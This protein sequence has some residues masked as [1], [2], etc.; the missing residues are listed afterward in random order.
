[1]D[2]LKK[3][4]KNEFQKFM[5]V[6][7]SQVLGA[8]RKRMNDLGVL[9]VAEVVRADCQQQDRQLLTQLSL[10][11]TWVDVENP[12]DKISVPWY[13]QGLDVGEKGPG[14]AYT[15]GEKY[16]LLK[17]FNI[18]TDKDDPDGQNSRVSQPEVKY[19]DGPGE[20]KGL[21]SAEQLEQI[22]TIIRTNKLDPDSVKDY[23]VQNGM[24]Q[25]GKNGP[26]PMTMASSVAEEVLDRKDDFVRAFSRWTTEP[27]TAPIPAS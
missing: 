21:A 24:I 8:L 7:S 19:K 26:D 23:M 12:E 13:A 25:L 11:Y 2:S 18:P 4:N 20:T 3:D 9:L 10:N 17:F 1:M 6:S 22:A 14:K 27:Q 16:F 5:F 15:Y